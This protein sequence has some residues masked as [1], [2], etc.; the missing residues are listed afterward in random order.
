MGPITS[1]TFSL[2]LVFSQEFMIN[3][4]EVNF[5]KLTPHGVTNSNTGSGTPVTGSGNFTLA[6]PFAGTGIAIGPDE[7]SGDGN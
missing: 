5:K 3:G 1:D 7:A 6:F 2:D 4:Q